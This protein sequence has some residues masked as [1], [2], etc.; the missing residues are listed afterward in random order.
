MELSMSTPT[1]HPVGPSL[2]TRFV[3]LF[4]VDA[5]QFQMPIQ[6]PPRDRDCEYLNRPYENISIVPTK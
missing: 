3:Q 1:N 5:D 6:K 2:G 4:E